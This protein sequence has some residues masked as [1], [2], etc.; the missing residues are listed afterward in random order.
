[1]N[2]GRQSAASTFFNN[3]LDVWD[4]DKINKYVAPDARPVPFSNMIFIGDGE[5]ARYFDRPREL[6]HLPRGALAG[7]RAARQ[8]RL[9][10][11]L[12]KQRRYDFRAESTTSRSSLV[13]LSPN[14]DG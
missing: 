12:V 6:Q 5:A 8:A 2:H 3:L 14:S 13:H 1:M 4:H 11:H 9:P 10:A 7:R